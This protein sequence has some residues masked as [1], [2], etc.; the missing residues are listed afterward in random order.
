MGL[1]RRW[2]QLLPLLGLVATE[3]NAA[4]TGNSIKVVDAPPG[5]TE[6]ATAREAVTDIYFGSR[7]VGEARI[8][9]RPGAIRFHDPAE[10]L[11]FLPNVIRSAELLSA[12][13]RELPSNVHQICPDNVTL[14]CGSL[15]PDPVGVIFNEDRFRLDIFVNPK[16]L[17]V[18]GPAEERFLATPDAP[19]SL[20]SSMGLALSGS[21]QSSPTYNLQ[22]RT[23][24]G[25]RNA[26]IRSTSSY[27]SNFGL[28]VDTAVAELDQPGL[29]YSAG[30][31]WAPGLDLTGHR[32][33][34]GLGVATQFDTRADRD[35]LR[36]TPLI[37]FLPQPARVDVLV[38]GRLVGSGLYEV[39][40]NVLDTSGMPEG[41]YS[42]VLRIQ[43]RSGA[44]REERRFF[45][46]S[47]HIAPV[48]QPIYFA[49]GGL[50][51]NSRPGRAISVSDGLFYQVGTAHRLSESLAVDTSLI[52]T[53]KKPLVEVGAWVITPVA[54][55]RF[56]GLVSFKGD[57]GA[58]FQ[59]S[60][61]QT[62]PFT[63]S[64]DLR[65][66][67]AKD[68]KPLIPLPTQVDT[69][70]SVPLTGL[71]MEEGSY[72]QATGSI[73]YRIGSAYLAVIGSLRK[74]RGR[75]A[76]YSIGPNLNW[77]LLNRGGLQVAFQADG[78]LTRTTT[79]AYAG[80]RMLFTAGRYSVFSVVGR[81][82][83]SS[84]DAGA[85]SNW[86]AVASTQAQYSYHHDEQTELSFSAGI[87]RD[88]NSSVARAGGLLYSR[89]GSVRGEILKNFEGDKATQYA[90]TLQS[91]AALNQDNAI[92][93]G[94]NLDES[95]VVVSVGGT[96][97]DAEFDVLINEQPRGRIKPGARLPIFLPAYRQ[98]NVRLRPV[99][100][101]AVWYDT[102][103]RE[104][105]LYPGNVRHLN[106]FAEQV[107]TV[108]GRAVMVDGSPVADAVVR[109]RRGVGQSDTSG[110]FQVDVT[111][112][113]SLSFASVQQG[114]CTV[115]L[116]S[117][118]PREN[119]AAVGKVICR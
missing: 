64:L 39:G 36:G 32:R 41:S 12:M 9:A 49:Y 53:P 24:V 105:S 23:I 92:F 40:N 37:L 44:V 78:Q 80:I 52:G 110:Y 119:F 74:D 86:R 5:F 84:R 111:K 51:A 102:A 103:V 20:T 1:P 89:Y 47:V 118:R 38:D 57:R 21:D 109:S 45:A 81:R 100:A 91:G 98:Y 61:A 77:P 30:M 75:S 73:G 65:R 17:E 104:V 55:A 35:H 15:S 16:W 10:V 112:D 22:N 29:R 68:N 8:T 96:A 19:I 54:R 27:A 42:V 25:F 4:A 28:V 13:Q 26:R 107:I 88:L 90:L 50:L 43:E 97:A 31:F 6:L 83:S 94:R 70:D 3:A 115:Q 66:I 63:L 11:G 106:W 114:D 48:G 33:I 117:L 82:G 99:D 108:F 56:A 76:D 72:T 18:V 34:L 59:V 58:L 101:A 87:D 14:N 60:S 67:W 93:G 69:F 2:L 113:D 62:G 71:Q 95:A 79:A 116:H 46:K 7:K 85:P